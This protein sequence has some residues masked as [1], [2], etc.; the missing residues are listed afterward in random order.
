MA[1]E[2]EV[3]EGDGEPEVLEL[4]EEV[5][6]EQEETPD[7]YADLATRIGWVPKDQFRGDPEAWKPAEQFILD[8][9]DI[10]RATSR[11]LKEMRA[12]VDNI[13]RTT[14]TLFEQRMNEYASQLKTE[15]ATA[16]EDGDPNR[17]WEI[18]QKLNGLSQQA[19]PTVT[20][21]AR[22]WVARN[23]WFEKDPVAKNLAMAV[24][25]TYAKEGKSVAEQLRAAETHVRQAYPNLF[26]SAGKG[27]AGVAQPGSRSAS[28]PGKAKSFADMPRAAQDI[29][30]DLVDRKLI[31]NTDAY[32]KNY[33]ATE[34]KA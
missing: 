20:S 21:E 16:V 13:A 5:A 19:P 8:G 23:P 27:P 34:G 7:P 4:T 33:Y 14:G 1:D 18:G 25:D 2:N 11:E 30:K 32:V 17:A 28:P 6:E 26:A 22:E 24:A 10:Q 12:T 9:K 15:Y 29:A 31:P 3:P